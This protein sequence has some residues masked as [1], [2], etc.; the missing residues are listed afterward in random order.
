MRLA[1]PVTRLTGL[2]LKILEF[3]LLKNLFYSTLLITK[4][5]TSPKDPSIGI[6]LVS[7][8][9]PAFIMLSECYTWHLSSNCHLHVPLSLS[10]RILCF[11]VDTIILRRHVNAKNTLFYMRYRYP[12]LPGNEQH[13]QAPYTSPV[14]I[15]LTNSLW[16]FWLF[17]RR[18]ET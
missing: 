2:V 14:L 9:M 3:G 7:N 12:D 10:P 4:N 1:K 15:L 6:C 17:L 5:S 16:L 8:C 11:Y 13:R 18:V